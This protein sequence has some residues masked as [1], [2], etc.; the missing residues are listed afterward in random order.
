MVNIFYHL[1]N[2]YISQCSLWTEGKLI[3]PSVQGMSRVRTNGK[4]VYKGVF[5]Y[6]FKRLISSLH[7]DKRCTWQLACLKGNQTHNHF[8]RSPISWA[9]AIFFFPLVGTWCTNIL[10]ATRSQDYLRSAVHTN[11][12]SVKERRNADTVPSIDS[13]SSFFNRVPF[14]LCKAVMAISTFVRQMLK[15]PCHAVALGFSRKG[16]TSTAN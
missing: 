14:L 2:V 7:L 12:T 8:N 13:N 4:G 3:F 1:S 16:V 9:T 5:S 15:D 10:M 11:Y 6:I